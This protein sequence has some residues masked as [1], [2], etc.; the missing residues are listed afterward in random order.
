MAAFVKMSLFQE[1]LLAVLSY[2]LL[3]PLLPL[4]LLLLLLPVPFSILY[5]IVGPP[6]HLKLS[7]KRMGAPSSSALLQLELLWGPY[8]Q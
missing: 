4:L 6:Q 7:E 2:L 5:C 8:M 1:L 3:M